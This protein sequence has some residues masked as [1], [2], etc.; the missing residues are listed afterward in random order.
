MD[1]RSLRHVFGRDRRST[2]IQDFSSHHHDDAHHEAPPP[3]GRYPFHLNLSQIFEPEAVHTIEAAGELVFHT[4]GDTGNKNH[5]SEAQLAVA[6]HMVSQ[7]ETLHGAV[8]PKFFYHL[9]DV[10]Y[11]NGEKAGYDSEFYEPYQHYTA[12]IVAIPGNH[13]GSIGDDGTVPTLEGFRLNFCAP[14]PMHTAMAG[15]SNRTTMIQP[16]FYWT[17]LTP[18]A[19]MI[20]LYSNVDGKIDV[21]N[22]SQQDWLTAELK[23]AR[24]RG[25]KCILV[26]VHHPPYSLDDSHGGHAAIQRVIDTAIHDSDVVPTAILSGHVHDYQRFER[27]IGGKI[28]PYI[29]A[30]AGGYAGY[31]NLHQ[32]KPGATPPPGVKLIK[33]NTQLPGFLKVTITRKTFG[34]EYYTVPRLDGNLPGSTADLFESFSYSL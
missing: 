13:D 28:I 23:A 21:R 10:V 2:Q 6:H 34:G 32:L 20:G 12:P 30:G 16:N 9:G 25:D 19:S 31:H 4:V 7:L 33:A 3:T 22:T 14:Q 11:F 29:V 17:L 1:A 8:Q 15:H 18:L 5:G 26:M 27:K 24:Q